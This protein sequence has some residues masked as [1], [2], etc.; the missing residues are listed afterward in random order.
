MLNAKNITNIRS[1]HRKSNPG[2]DLPILKTA[3][4]KLNTV[5]GE[6]GGLRR[7][8]LVVIAADKYNYREGLV[9]DIYLGTALVNKPTMIDESKTPVI[10]DIAFGGTAREYQ[11]NMRAH[12]QEI[13]GDTTSEDYHLLH[14]QGYRYFSFIIDQPKDFS[15][16]KLIS[17]I[18]ELESSGHEIHLLT[19]GDLSH[20][21]RSNGVGCELS[22][23]EMMRRIRHF[24]NSRGCTVVCSLPINDDIKQYKFDDIEH[25]LRTVSNHSAFG[26]DKE[27]LQT[28]DTV[29]TIQ[30]DNKDLHVHCGKHRGTQIKQD[31]VK[32]TMTDDCVFKFDEPFVVSMAD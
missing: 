23:C 20:M 13:T 4:S 19:I 16:F 18:N 2:Y 28:A 14:C 22:L 12:Y 25:R 9:N 15:L 31:I 17:Y 10:I 11:K 3:H 8:E 24:F 5:L 30:L 29:L 1:A 7:G 27:I 26:D 6:I 32:L 21:S